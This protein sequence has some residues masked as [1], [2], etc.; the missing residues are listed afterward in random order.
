MAWWTNSVG[1]EIGDQPAD[2]VSD[3]LEDVAERCKRPQKDAFF[4]ALA[5][6]FGKHAF[7]DG[8]PKALA[9]VEMAGRRTDH[10]GRGPKVDP[11]LVSAMGGVLDEI[12]RCYADYL[13]RPPRA[14]E[15]AAVFAFVLR[16][17]PERFMSGAEGFE[18]REITPQPAKGSAA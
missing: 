4:A 18:L 14:S 12:D 13:E 17:E 6:A 3:V 7:K 16:G 8:K 15:A 1:D 10:P 9:I 11:V 5:E 2:L